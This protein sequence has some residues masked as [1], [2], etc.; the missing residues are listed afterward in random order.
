[1]LSILTTS[2][3]LVSSGTFAGEAAACPGFEGGRASR[4]EA[5]R[6]YVDR[7]L[8]VVRAAS[9]NDT[10]ALSV[11]VADDARFEVWRGDYTSSARSSGPVGAIQMVQDVRP[12]W[13]EAQSVAN[14]PISYLPFPCTW[15]VALLFRT[16]QP[17]EG[18][19]VR[20]SFLDGRLTSAVGH[21]VTLL[22]GNVR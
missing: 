18:V 1:M 20:F 21:A 9:E 11:V 16:G 14:G 15:E 6:F 12:V 7:A 13:F 8:S 3:L 22:E 19:S 10:A 17:R 5:D 2:M 4:V